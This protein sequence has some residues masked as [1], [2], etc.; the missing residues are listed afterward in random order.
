MKSTY[1]A[2]GV[3]V[4]IGVLFFMFKKSNDVAPS[5]SATDTNTMEVTELKI[6]DEVVGT[7]A[8]AVA[9]DKV[10][11][12][13]VG[14]LTNGTVFDASRSHGDQ[15]FTFTLGAGQVIKGWDQG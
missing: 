5:T 10:T 12:Q 13:Y 3:I 8:T 11:V 6:E 7:G 14:S 15:G 9:G 1:I 4:I 2:I